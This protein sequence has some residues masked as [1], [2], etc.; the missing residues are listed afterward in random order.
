MNSPQGA[1]FRASGSVYK[2]FV[3]Q[4]GKCAFLTVEFT[5][6]RGRVT[7]LETRTFDATVI[8]Q[9]RSLGQGEVVEVTGSIESEVAK[10]KAKQDVSVDGRL[11]W[12]PM[13]KLKSVKV[14]G[15]AK[16]KA[17]APVDLDDGKPEGWD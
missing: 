7:K 17:A 3:P 11:L 9:V 6:D 10:D 5:N 13:L 16:A 12:I 8:Q 1:G 2:A 4:S 15:A 14:D